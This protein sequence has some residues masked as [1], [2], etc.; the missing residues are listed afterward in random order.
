MLEAIRE[1]A[2][3]W[4]AK[5]ILALIIIPFALWGIDSYFKGDGKE[6]AVA[7]VGKDEIGQREFFQALQS[8]RDALQQRLHTKIDI[9]NKD[10]RTGV[11]DQLVNTTLM[12]QAGRANGLVVPTGQIEAMIQSAQIFQSNGAFSEDLFQSWLQKQGLTKQGL[13][14]L[15]QQD[16]YVQQFQMGYGQG[17]LVST[18]GVAQL[19]GLLAQQR[20]VN[21]AVFSVKDYAK[22]VT[23]DDKAVEAE[24]NAHKADYA[25]PA[26]V[27]VQYLVLSADAIKSGIDI[28]DQAARQY[29]E[30]NKV[31]YQQ[32]EQRHASHILIK[33]DSTMSAADQAA[34]K[35][36]AEKIY[37]ELRAAPG[38][39]A[40][41]AK[42]DSQ[43]PGSAANGGDLGS[44]TRDTM[45]KPFADA[46]FSMKVGELSPPVKTEYGYHIIRLDGITPGQQVPFESVKAEIVGQ[47]AQQEAERKFADEAD[48][49]SNMVYEQSDSLDPAAKQFNLKVQESGWMSRDHA[50]PALLAKP[51]LMDAIFSQDSLDKRQ[52]TEAIE[53]A[54]DTLVSARVVDY[55]PAGTRPLSEVSADIRAR[56]VAQAAKAKAVQAGEQ[57]L[58]QAQA[59]QAVAGLGAPMTVS[60]M[61]P[62]NLSPDSIKAIFK[63]DAGK[64]PAAIGVATDDG[65]HLFRL[66]R[67]LNPAPPEAQIQGIQRDLAG[68]VMKQE[69]DAYL[70]YAKAKA[71]VKID[72]AVLEKKAD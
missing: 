68:V 11:L 42:Q 10:F 18:A 12:S 69:M 14:R 70:A 31:K 62:L 37:Q 17:A 56:L 65:Y 50:D 60:R 40:E 22:G 66:T 15:L 47:L 16:S 53:V 44:F 32:P 25:V 33:A 21:E 4:I 59:G 5:L 38:K 28:S 43:D 36:K 39:F 52:N 30:A 8:Q 2:Q 49:F 45:V 54:T 3:G 7:K 24:Y 6:Q 13:I 57:A 48:K 55:K 41:L 51:E 64:L 46:V 67:V 23:V 34:A 20:E 26:Q 63:A 35:A 29:Y 61:Q 58:K 19:A 1:H 9:D 71:G 72:D 27:R